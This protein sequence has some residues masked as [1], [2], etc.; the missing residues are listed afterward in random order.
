MRDQ[1]CT[2]AG[3]GEAGHLVEERNVESYHVGYHGYEPV[4]EAGGC[5]G[6]VQEEA[7]RDYGF[8][9]EVEFDVDEYR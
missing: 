1:A 7:D 9:G 6:A 5:D 4:C 3:R 2:G 8:G